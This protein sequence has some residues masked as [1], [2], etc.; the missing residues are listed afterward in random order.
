MALSDKKKV[1]TMVNVAGQQM[2]II[3]NA[4]AVIDTVKTAFQAIN[5][6]VTGTPLDGNVSALNTA[7]TLLK[8]ESDKTL[9]T[10]LMGAIVESHRN[11]AL[12]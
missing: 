2:E 5:P 4:V 11:K 6:D 1:Q 3:R 12:E 7:F 10:G 8:A 9:W